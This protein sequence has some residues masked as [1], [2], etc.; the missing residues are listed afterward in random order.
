MRRGGNY[1]RPPPRLRQI[2]PR[3]R[4]ARPKR[5]REPGSGTLAVKTAFHAR[6]P[7][8]PKSSQGLVFN[9]AEV[10]LLKKL[11]PPPPSLSTSEAVTPHAQNSPEL[12]SLARR[13]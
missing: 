11:N 1:P 5:G 6:S 2:A 8:S 13:E 9:C 12:P 4:S 10:S 3:P 7:K